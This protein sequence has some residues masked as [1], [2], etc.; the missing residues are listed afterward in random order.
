MYT[1]I[2]QISKSLCYMKNASDHSDFSD[3]N[4][5]YINTQQIFM[6]WYFPAVKFTSDAL[7]LYRLKHKNFINE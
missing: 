7:F 5:G 1:F 6:E 3:Q 4:D 2:R